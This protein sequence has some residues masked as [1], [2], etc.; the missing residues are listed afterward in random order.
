MLNVMVNNRVAALDATFS[1]LA[2]P[3]RRA[4][5]ARLAA[6]PET[7]VTEL[8]RPFAVSLPAI[9][10][11]LCILE[12]AGLVARRQRGRVHHLRL[13]PAPLESAGGWI[14][15]YRRFW[16]SRLDALETYLGGSRRERE[17]R[18]GRPRRPR[19]LRSG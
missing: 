14:E 11:H 18:P 15:T 13:L 6:A 3:T 9:S 16:E 2:H 17:K 1:A 7:T 8:A 4:M 10:R 12:G 5:M 19:S